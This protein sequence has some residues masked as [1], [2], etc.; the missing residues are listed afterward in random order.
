M[1]IE[2]MP[3]T[4]NMILYNDAMTLGS[5]E[6]PAAAGSGP[7]SIR[8]G[9][10]AGN[11]D[12]TD[13]RILRELARDARLP[14]NTLAQRA[15]IAPSTCLARVRA[16]REHGVIRGYHADIDP[17]AL[18]RPLQAMVAVRLQAGARGHLR[19]FVAGMARLPEVLNVFFLAG[20]DDFLLHIAAASSPG[21]RDFVERL[22]ANAD[23][24]YTE[25]SLIF[26]H[27]QAGKA[28]L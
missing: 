3:I 27:V 8:L 25:T 14:N 5:S 15:G 12:E 24:A 20:K 19:S 4:P 13:R 16:L 11:L 28:M 23:V 7:K 6:P 21:L 9:S 2:I 26:E 22:S 1:I 18:G 10:E 17:A